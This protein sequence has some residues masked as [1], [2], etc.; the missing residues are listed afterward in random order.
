MQMFGQILV[1]VAEHDLGP[2]DFGGVKPKQILEILLAERG[3]SVS[4]ARLADHLWGSSLPRNVSGT[5]ETYISV[6]RRRLDHGGDQGK[7][8]VLTE[9]GAY[10]FA[11]EEVEID[12]NRFD[13]LANRAAQVDHHVARPLLNEAL[14]LARGEILEDEPYAEWLDPLRDQYRKRVR[15]VRLDS[16]EAALAGTDFQAALDHA[17]KA[18]SEDPH[19]EKAYRLAML[20]FYA[21]GRQKEALETYD[22]C[23]ESLTDELG[24]DPLEE[25]RNL[26]MSILRQEDA[27][28]LLPRRRERIEVLGD[29][30]SDRLPLL[31]RTEELGQIHGMI[32]AAMTG[33]FALVMVEGESG[34]GKS[35]FLD[36]VGSDLSEVR[37][38]RARCSPV[39]KELPYVPLAMALREALQDISIDRS[40]FPGLADVLPELWLSNPAL[41]IPQ[42]KVLETIAE[43]IREHA[44]MVLLL[45]DSQWADAGTVAAMG[46]LQRRLGDAAVSIIVAYD[47][48]ELN[49]EDPLHSLDSAPKIKLGPLSAEDL[50]PLGSADLHARTGGHPLFVAACVGAKS[51]GDAGNLPPTLTELVVERARAEGE[52][53]HRI[54]LSASVMDQP[55]GP[56]TL[57]VLLEEDA[58]ELLGELERLSERKLLKFDGD[59]FSFRVELVREVLSHSMSP[60]RRRLLQQRAFDFESL[61][62]VAGPGHASRSRRG[63]KEFANP[64]DH[65]TDGID[66]GPETLTAVV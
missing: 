27:A 22:R 5:L 13:F 44:P 6:L 3:G 14:E 36:S 26:H 48:E 8:L 31:G 37:L 9:P 4:K 47:P 50:A 66:R 30:M 25:T 61:A 63:L 54:L 65:E 38:G 62:S 58:F 17:E 55:F 29:V 20:G 1:R 23:R 40:R 32:S 64:G 21:L 49:A 33:R 53:A 46:Y 11:I 10:R 39:E 57:A 43:L 41:E 51:E 45:D 34:I 15:R 56:E 60:A 28:S 24:V 42:V 35:R 59:G 16:A 52:R 12:L 19:N 18:L 7:A 2:R